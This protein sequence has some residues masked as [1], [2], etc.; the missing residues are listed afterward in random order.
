MFLAAATASATTNIPWYLSRSTGMVAYLLLF[1]TV[2]LGIS[3]RTKGLDRVLARWRVTDLHTFLSIMVLVFV[4]I[5]AGILL[6]DTF[7]GFKLIQ[8]LVPF[9]APYRPIW[10]S[11][12]IISAYLLIIISLSFLARRW[13]G[14]RA[15]RTLHYANFAIYVGALVH[16]MYTGTDSPTLWADAIYFFSAATV[17]GLVL[18]RIVLWYQH[19]QERVNAAARAPRPRAAAPG[20]RPVASFMST[21]ALTDRRNQIASRARAFGFMSVGTMAIVLVAAAIGPFKW[22]A[23]SNGDAGSATVDATGFADNFNGTVTSNE[24]SRGRGTIDLRLLAQ[25]QRDATLDMNF[26]VV[27]LQQGAQVLSSTAELTD[28]TGNQLCSGTVT[29]MDGV[30]FAITCDGSGPYSGRTV[31]ISGSIDNETD[32]TVSGSM[33]VQLQ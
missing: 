6:F 27:V 18:Y 12:G 11:F 5:H 30:N 14:Y 28:S 3:V 10:T 26:D 8:I 17:L 31:F 19:E 33:S 1:G 4:A 20:A 2:V 16:G 32:T 22:F 25:G 23:A 9:S 7:M 21:Y 24:T 29:Q 13:I 15:W